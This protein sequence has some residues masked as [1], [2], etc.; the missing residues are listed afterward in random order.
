[1]VRRMRRLSLL[2][3]VLPAPTFAQEVT[4]LPEMTVRA[5]ADPL[6]LRPNDAAGKI[7]F[8]REDIEALDAASVGAL[9][10]REHDRETGSTFDLLNPE[11]R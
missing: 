9:A 3:A 2:L 7:V 4:L 5:T 10:R 1:V 11:G 8:G 6:E